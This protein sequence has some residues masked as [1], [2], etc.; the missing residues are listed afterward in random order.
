M[1][2]YTELVKL[3][4]PEDHIPQPQYGQQVETP[5]PKEQPAPVTTTAPNSQF[6]NNAPQMAPAQNKL[7]DWTGFVVPALAL[8]NGLKDKFSGKP[9]PYAQ[10]QKKQL[11][12]LTYA[13]DMTTRPL[14]G[15]NY[16]YASEDRSNEL[17]L[18]IGG[19]VA[20]GSGAYLLAKLLK[21]QY[22]L[23]AIPPGF[24]AGQHVGGML[25][26]KA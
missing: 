6:R 16:K 15:R 21:M 5:K 11:R 25:A 1:L 7:P 22:P 10:Q 12:P 9:D 18:R 14:F 23:A 26:G 4:A 24:I 3:A 8:F 19:G 17:A 13:N 2:S 20:G